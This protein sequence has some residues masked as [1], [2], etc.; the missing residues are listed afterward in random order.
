M[1]VSF[2]S[3]RARRATRVIARASMSQGKMVVT[4]R[5]GCQQGEGDE[6]PATETKR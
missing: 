1:L 5:S 3:T 4:F 6:R 2:D